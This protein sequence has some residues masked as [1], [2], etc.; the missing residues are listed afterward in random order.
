MTDDLLR[1]KRY[2]RLKKS[3]EAADR[4]G[5]EQPTPKLGGRKRK[6]ANENTAEPKKRKVEDA[7]SALGEKEAEVLKNEDGAVGED[8][9]QV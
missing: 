3:M 6:A 2:S 4:S 5:T 9:E 8:E 7:T 1:Q